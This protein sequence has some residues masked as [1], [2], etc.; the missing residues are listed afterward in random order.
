KGNVAEKKGITENG[1][2]K[3]VTENATTA[4]DIKVVTETEVNRKGI[5]EGGLKK[6]EAQ[7]KGINANQYLKN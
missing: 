4:A 6:N 3:N 5:N 7:R 2:K 1:L